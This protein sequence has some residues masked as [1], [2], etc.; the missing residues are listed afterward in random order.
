MITK[1]RAVFE[2]QQ[3]IPFHLVTI[4]E[5][6]SR[7]CATI[8]RQL[9]DDRQGIGGKSGFRVNGVEIEV[10]ADDYETME[11]IAEKITDDY[12][13]EAI[14]IGGKRATV[15]ITDEDDEAYPGQDGSDDWIY[16]RTLTMRIHTKRG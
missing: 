5:T 15:L 12:D 6:E 13:G 14:E 1:L 4:T 3:K 8:R 10:F 9:I 16:A 7:P 2:D 11:A